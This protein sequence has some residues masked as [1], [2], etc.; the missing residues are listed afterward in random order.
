MD[1]IFITQRQELNQRTIK[2]QVNGTI[3]KIK[4]SS[5]KVGSISYNKKNCNSRL[6]LNLLSLSDNVMFKEL[7]FLYQLALVNIFKWHK[8]CLPEIVHT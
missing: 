7:R 4:A 8:G 2:N 5:I 3:K 6:D 1:S